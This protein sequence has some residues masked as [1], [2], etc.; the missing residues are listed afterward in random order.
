MHNIYTTQAVYSIACETCD[1]ENVGKTLT[2]VGVQQKEHQDA[3]RLG[4]SVKSAIAEHVHESVQP[5]VIDWGSMKVLD[6]AASQTE[7]RIREA[8][9]MHKRQPAMNRDQGLDFSKV[10]KTVKQ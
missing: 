4:D 9:H 7:R 5:Y 2:A 6:K 1:G 8:V 10:W 3:V